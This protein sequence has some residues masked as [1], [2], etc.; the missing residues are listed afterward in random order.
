MAKSLTHSAFMRREE[1]YF[2][3][4]VLK[5]IHSRHSQSFLIKERAINPL[6]MSLKKKT[7]KKHS[8]LPI[9]EQIFLKSDKK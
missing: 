3:T 8:Y 1:K 9:L 7:K 2:V 4:V 6:F 5:F